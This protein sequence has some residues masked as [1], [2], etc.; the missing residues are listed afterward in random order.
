MHP[1]FMIEQGML[2]VS[3]LKRESDTVQEALCAP[4]AP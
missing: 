3:S 2:C 1:L 4:V